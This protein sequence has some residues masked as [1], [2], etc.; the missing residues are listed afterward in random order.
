M[1]LTK[2]WEPAVS[3]TVSLV[4]FVTVF[5]F[6]TMSVSVSLGHSEQLLFSC[7]SSKVTYRVSKKKT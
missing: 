2:A 7:L 1:F 6:V 5:V 4:V 3:V